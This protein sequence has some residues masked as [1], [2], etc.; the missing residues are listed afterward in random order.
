MA[1]ATG[2]I[3]IVDLNDV[4]LQGFLN[5]DQP[6]LQLLSTSG[7]YTP[8]WGVEANNVNITA[9][10][11]E[12][13]D[14]TNQAL[15]GAKAG[16]ATWSYK[17]VGETS[18]TTIISTTPGFTIG[19]TNSSQ[20]KITANKM[21]LTATGMT[22]RYTTNYAP[23]SGMETIPYKMDIEYGLSVQGQTGK[24][25]APTAV[26]YLSNENITLT[27][28][29]AGGVTPSQATTTM[30]ILLGTSD[31]SANWSYS[32]TATGC[33]ITKASETS[34]TVTLETFTSDTGY[35]DI[36][37]TKSGFP[38][39]T[40]RFTVSKSKV[41]ADGIPV[42]IDIAGPQIFAYDKEGALVGGASNKLTVTRTN[43]ASYSV[44]S[45]INNGASWETVASAANQILIS[46]DTV[47]VY[48]TASVW[49]LSKTLSI[50]V[51]SGSVSDVIT[52]YKV[53][54]GAAAK[55]L[56]IMADGY[57][58][59]TNSSGVTAPNYITLTA[60]KQNT[61]SNVTWSSS[62]SVALFPAPTGGT[63]VT[64]GNVVYVRKGDLLAAAGK[65]TTITAALVDGG[66]TFTDKTTV[67]VLT[68]GL[69]GLTVV[70]QNESSTVPA[71]YAGVVS[72]YS[73]TN[74]TLRVFEGATELTSTTATPTAGQYK[75]TAT[76]TPSGK[77]S[78]PAITVTG[79]PAVIS[80]FSGMSSTTDS[81]SITYSISG[82]RINGT[83]FGPL[84][85]SQT[86]TKSKA[87]K[88]SVL[89]T[90][91]APEGDTFTN[92]ALGTNPSL[93]LEARLIE[94]SSPKTPTSVLWFYQNPAV[95]ATTSTG[96]HAKGGLG[97]HSM[98]TDVAS[99]YT[100]GT[101]LTPTIYADFVPGLTAFKVVVTYGGADYS[102]SVVVRDFTDP[103]QLT[104]DSSNGLTFVDGI[105]SSTLTCIV[106]QNGVEIDGDG[107]LL[108]YSWTKT[109]KN[110]VPDTTWN[111][112]PKTLAKEVAITGSD[113]SK[114][115]TFTCTVTKK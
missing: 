72:D 68:E 67:S 99:K 36:K 74:N 62:P 77:I 63:A 37:A 28:N 97:W 56:E 24:D 20:L 88:D 41:G 57:T 60:K 90:A 87:G 106:R 11:Y 29:K 43:V 47:T 18:F 81:V 100:G 33:T 27:A 9:E 59:V 79:K 76:V 1:L 10:L 86:I 66:V 85:T 4:T 78:T 70:N 96:Y 2:Q 54:D 114:K 14:S 95:S 32:A 84:L 92:I 15:V 108:N 61:T 40:K 80:N 48:A 51:S 58:M 13:G 34:R 42:N 69:E 91:W 109:D 45:S 52:L 53:S 75:V 21:T 94:G 38:T 12:M 113:I 89:V 30:S 3:T 65:S 6:K 23:Q 7:T 82:R 71:S 110:G 111:A 17:L 5:S 73:M 39:I 102:D 25:A 31:D 107:T 98:A 16:G 19:G 101:T 26:G 115:A 35:V 103:Y 50:K 64:T 93:G 44:Q 49:S 105:I 83:A 112:L 46:G 22:I 55:S 104:L 8:N